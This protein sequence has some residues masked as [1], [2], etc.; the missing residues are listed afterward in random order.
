[1]RTIYLVACVGQ[2]N[3]YHTRAEFLYNSPWLRMARQLAYARADD[4]KILSAEHGLVAPGQR[5]EPYDASMR[6]MTPGQRREW[7]ADVQVQLGAWA[8]GWMY[9]SAPEWLHSLDLVVLAG[10]DYRRQFLDETDA[11]EPRLNSGQLPGLRIHIPM[12]GLGI[13]SQ[14]GW[15]KRQLAEVYS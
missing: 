1:M 6:S 9:A 2:K 13:G 7:G 10:L 4:W 15:M 5:L 12:A 8:R 14:L 11:R 3:P